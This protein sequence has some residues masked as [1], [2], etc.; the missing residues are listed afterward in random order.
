MAHGPPSRHNVIVPDNPLQQHTTSDAT[1]QDLRAIIATRRDLGPDYE[2]ALVDSFLDKLDVEIAARVRS[3]V[4]AQTA[5]I[6]KDTHRGKDTTV[7]VALGSLG[8]G[9]PLTAIASSNAGGAGLLLAWAGIICVNV[10]YAL[11]RRSSR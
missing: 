2:D 3:E 4:A 8:I 7:P 11:S 10:A 1:R 5:G 6:A 9:I